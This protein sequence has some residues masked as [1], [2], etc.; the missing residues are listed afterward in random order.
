MAADPT[1][2]KGSAAALVLSATAMVVLL[3]VTDLWRSPFV[4]AAISVFIL[5]PYRRVS[6]AHGRLFILLVGVTVGWVFWEVF[7]LLIPFIVAFVLAFIVDPLVS[8]LERRGFRRLLS[9]AGILAI[10]IA[11]AVVLSVLVFPILFSQL[12]TIIDSISTLYRDTG[13]YFESR[14]FLRLLRNL[15]LSKA[16]ANNI[17]REEIIPGLQNASSSIFGSLLHFLTSLSGIASQI[18]NIVLTPIFLFYFM[19]D[20]PRF[21]SGVRSLLAGKNDE[22]LA[23]LVAANGILRAYLGGQLIAAI[24]VGV[25]ASVCFSVLGIPNPVVLGLICG[26][27]NPIPYVGIFA[28]IG[29]SMLSSLITRGVS[30]TDDF[31]GIVAVVLG[32]HF[33]DNYIIQPRIVGQRVGLHPLAVVAALFIFG[34]FFGVAGLLVAVPVTAVC[35]MLLRRWLF[36]KRQVGIIEAVEQAGGTARQ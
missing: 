22:L 19:R 18:L 28:G 3:A 25:G 27:L 24:F 13:E 30:L 34:Y 1:R 12:N 35:G 31:V 11:C 26:V 17:V 33:I 6:I 29:I 2:E 10:L 9:T 23:D 8:W 5:A 20:F 32:L 36:S 7:S 14:E 16:T 15:G 21:R 4:L